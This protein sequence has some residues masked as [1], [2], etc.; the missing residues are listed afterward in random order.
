MNY[1]KRQLPN[2]I[3]ALN[4]LSGCLGVIAALENNLLGAACFVALGIFFDFFDG[5]AARLLQVK[6]ELGK[7]LDSLADLITS[8][9]VPGLVLYTLLNGNGDGL[10]EVLFHN[11][12]PLTGLIVPVA[13]AYRLA[14]FNIDTRQED[15]FIGLPTP[16]TALL[17]LSVPC[18]LAY[19]SIPGLELY[20]TS[21]YF[22]V[23]LAVFCALIMNAPLPLF[24]LKFS[25]FGWQENK[26]RYLFLATGLFWMALWQFTGLAFL[27]LTYVISG[28]FKVK[29]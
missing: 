9:L 16:A 22:L 1:I 26:L 25:S 11:P 10:Y 6:S 4:L 20:L 29:N 28:F 27:I 12:L 18:M 15:G 24:S 7:Q 19:P 14:N 23:G 21:P 13:A 2:A 17:I 8:G 3:T 5:F